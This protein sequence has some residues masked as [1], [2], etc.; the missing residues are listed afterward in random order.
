MLES[1]TIK[2]FRNLE[3][4]KLSFEPWV[5]AIYGDNWRWKTSIIEAISLFAEESLWSSSFEHMLRHDAESFFLQVQTDTWVLALSYEKQTKKKKYFLN[6]KSVTKKK[7]FETSYRACIFSPTTMNMFLLWP[8]ERRFYMDSCLIQTYS[9]YKKL[10]KKYEKIIQQRNATLKSIQKWKSQVSELF[11]WNNEFIDLALSIYRYRYVFMQFLQ[12][13]SRDFHN[14]IA[15]LQTFEICY[16]SKIHFQN[17]EKDLLYFIETEQEKEIIMWRTLVWP[18][19]DD[20]Q[21][22]VDD[23]ELLYRASR[24]EM[25]SIIFWLKVLEAEFIEEKTQKKPIILI[26]DFMS[27]LDLTHQKFVL[28]QGENYQIILS[29]IRKTKA[30]NPYF[31]K[32]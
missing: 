26:D 23:Q 18:H 20:L 27:E 8:K 10:H 22:Y 11:F 3:S 32:I 21:I 15:N 2:N 7:F 17:P 1:I 24:W 14:S 5:N 4:L 16:E 28:K 6:K 30:W 31:I 29:D 25:K 19:L 9:G 13:H 12:K